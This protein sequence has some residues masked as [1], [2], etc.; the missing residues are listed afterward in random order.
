LESA[1]VHGELRLNGSVVEGKF[2]GAAM[3][4]DHNLSLDRGA[5]FNM[6]DLTG[7][8]SDGDFNLSGSTFNSSVDMSEAQIGGE[9]SLEFNDDKHGR[10]EVTW[11]KDAVLTLRNAK[12]D[13]IPNS[14]EIWPANIVL[15]GFTYRGLSSNGVSEGEKPMTDVVVAKSDNFSPQAYEQLA[16][17]LQN[18]GETARARKVLYALRKAERAHAQD[19]W[20]R[21][22]LTVLDWFIGYGYYLQ[23]A[24]YWAVVFWFIGG[25]VMFASGQ[26]RRFGLGPLG[27]FVYSFDM[28]LPIIRLREKNYDIDIDGPPQF[29]FYFHKIMGYILAS[30]LIAG[31][32][33][34]AK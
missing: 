4:I 23:R 21:A 26:Y 14:S 16:T 18:E 13:L 33:G 15:D 11:S 25:V 9:L 29:Y 17:V 5:I 27:S 10:S 32:A 7:T 12:V 30:F 20:R 2:D 24:L 6:V 28:L 8:K 3:K 31:L 22:G 34:L 19:P 1:I